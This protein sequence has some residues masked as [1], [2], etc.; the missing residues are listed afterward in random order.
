MPHERERE[1][2]DQAFALSHRGIRVLLLV[3][4]ILASAVLP[5]DLERDHVIAGLF[6]VF[7]LQLA[8]PSLVLATTSRLPDR[9]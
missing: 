1:R 2:R 7:L 5:V 3:S 9:D 6:A 8:A 4:V